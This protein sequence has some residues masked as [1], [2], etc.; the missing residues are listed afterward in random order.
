MKWSFLQ[1][2]MLRLCVA[3]FRKMGNLQDIF[4]KKMFDFI[5]E[6]GFVCKLGNYLETFFEFLLNFLSKLFYM[7]K[8]CTYLCLVLIKKKNIK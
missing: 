7:I 4:Y 6:V 1:N 2:E 3:W 5:F 8:L